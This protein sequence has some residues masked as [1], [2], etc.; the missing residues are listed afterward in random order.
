MVSGFFILEVMY[1]ILQ[2]DIWLDSGYQKL[3][4][5]RYSQMPK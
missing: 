1:C 3:Q 2:S 4:N 5:R